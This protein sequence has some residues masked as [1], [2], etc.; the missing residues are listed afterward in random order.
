[1]IVVRARGIATLA[2]QIRPWSLG[3]AAERTLRATHRLIG[4]KP[5]TIRAAGA[6]DVTVRTIVTL[7]TI[8]GQVANGPRRTMRAA[9]V[10]AA[11]LVEPTSVV[12]RRG[13]F[14]GSFAGPS[15]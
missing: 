6:V 11:D 12:R 4:G 7:Q 1:M 14:S 15:D 9:G 10:A 5:E 13:L 8:I 3:L 2:G